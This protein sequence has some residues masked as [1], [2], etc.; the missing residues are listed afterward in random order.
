MTAQ[1]IFTITQDQPLPKEI[2]VQFT[3]SSFDQS[4]LV[5]PGEMIASSKY[6]MRGH[7]TF[8]E[9]QTDEQ[10]DIEIE[11]EETQK[12]EGLIRSSLGG[13]VER[14]NKLITV[15][16]LSGRYRPEVG[17]LVIG[18]IT[19]VQSKRWKVEAG[20]RQHAVLMLGSVNLPGGVQRRKLESDEL[21]MRLFFQEGDLL[22]AEVQ[23]FFGDGSMSLHT[24][25]RK[26]GKLRNGMLLKVP[27][28]LILRLKSHFHILPIGIDL[29]IGVNGWIWIAQQRAKS[30]A[31]E[32]LKEGFEAETD[33][34]YSDVNEPISAKTRANI[35]RLA[36]AINLLSTYSMPISDS[37]IIRTYK[38]SLEISQ[39]SKLDHQSMDLDGPDDSSSI[40][41][42]ESVDGFLKPDFREKVMALL[43]AT[44]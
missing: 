17:D 2:P 36:G 24:R 28:Q 22:V 25:S 12:T 1:S 19:E 41:N 6:W 7:G 32:T 26:Y 14:I 5:V 20:G 33:N 27:S 31:E 16:P 11:G 8:I 29:I 39:L 10:D 21:Q 38:A 34:M 40:T 30:E 23:G 18:R 43:V 37:S 13:T 3:G 44:S 15:S 4:T 42:Q 35:A 9:D